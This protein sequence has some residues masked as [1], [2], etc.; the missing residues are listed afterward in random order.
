MALFGLKKK[1]TQKIQKIKP[2]IVRTQNVA[3]ELLTMSQ[4]FKMPIESFDFTILDVKTY[5][6]MN[7]ESAE[8][9]WKEVEEH[10]AYELDEAKLLLNE[11]FQIKQMYE[12]EIFSKKEDD[13]YKDFKVAVGAN[14]SKCKVYLSILEKSQITYNPQLEH[15]FRSLIN[16]RK[17]RAGILINIFDEMLENVVSKV[18]SYIRV[19]ETVVYEKTQTYLIAESLE[20]IPTQNDEII[21]HFEKKEE[22]DEHKKVDYASRGFIKDVK[23][24]EL[25]IE[26]K[27]AK[28]GKPGRNCR[29][30]YLKVDKVENTNLPTFNVDSTIAKIEEEDFIHY[31]AK[32]NGYIAFEDN[33]YKIKTDVD[34]NQISFKTTGSIQSGLDS[35]VSVVVTEKDAIK[36][37]VGTGMKVE[38]SE[39]D[40]DGNV[41]SNAEVFAIKAKIGGQTHRSSIVRADKLDINV[42]KGTAYGKNVHITRLE[43]GVVECD[44]AEISQAVG[45]TIKAKSVTVELCASHVKVTASRLIEIKQMQGSENRFVIDPLLKR[46]AQ[47]DL[48]KNKENIK[49]LEQEIRA[50]KKEHTELV[51]KVKDGTAAFKDL[52]KR[53]MHYKKNGI[54]MPASFVKKYKQFQHLQKQVEI[55]KNDLQE[56][57]HML[58]LLDASTLSFQD[59]IFDA[60]IINRDKWIG[61]NEIIFKLVDP[62]IEIKYNPPE[63]SPNK[64]FALVEIEEGEYEIEAVEE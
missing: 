26:Y 8:G 50:L 62:P 17:L 57:E 42:H 63:G 55:V 29:G 44:E 61:Y 45:G 37:A 12:I 33:T 13:P 6:R 43:H 34:I 58:D 15:D 25:L 54:K 35:D 53:L 52:K 21:M 9:E 38:V 4:S 46:S 7:T 22:L 3:K 40:I 59:N 10:E 47:A 51:Q 36:D 64:I 48:G 1:K 16:K 14:S 31:Q 24:G 23:K 5:T 20:A 28:E 39:I 60:R 32:E 49:K 19:N 2:T 18:V 27:K 56:K 30:E 41:G 11:F